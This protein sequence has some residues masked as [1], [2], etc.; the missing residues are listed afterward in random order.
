MER[1]SS[2]LGFVLAAI[3]SAVGIGNIWRFSSVL[4]QNG[5]GAYLV[6]YLIA[7][8]LC[9]VPLMVLELSVGRSFRGTV[10]TAFHALGPRARFIGWF[11]A[12]VITL[13]LSYYLVITGWTLA[14]SWFAFAGQPLDFPAFSSS[15]LPV[16]F[17]LLSILLTGIIVSAGIRKGIERIT[18]VLIPFVFVLLIGMAAFAATLPGFQAG[19][20]YLFTN[21]HKPL[22]MRRLFYKVRADEKT[23][24]VSINYQHCPVCLA[25]IMDTI[26]PAWW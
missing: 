23:R 18:T 6:P 9:A 3:G 24:W 13:I 20:A 25:T 26:S 1:W 4:G 11:I 5:G 14:F 16:F 12:G 10:V 7:R 17:F 8:F 19:L 15:L 21:G 2:S 22:A